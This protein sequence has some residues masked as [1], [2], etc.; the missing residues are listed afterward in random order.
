[1]HLKEKDD[2]SEQELTLPKAAGATKRAQRGES[3]ERRQDQ[4]NENANRRE[5]AKDIAEIVN[6]LRDS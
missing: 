4:E 3:E 6:A 1:M 5:K 2:Q